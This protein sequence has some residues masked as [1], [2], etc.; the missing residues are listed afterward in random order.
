MLE[1]IIAGIA[2]VILT[3]IVIVQYKTIQIYKRILT[4]DILK[5][6]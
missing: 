1:A 6:G 5:R 3:R 2:I 4:A